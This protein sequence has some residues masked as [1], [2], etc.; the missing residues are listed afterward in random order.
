[1]VA[2]YKHKNYPFIVNWVI[3]ILGGSLLGLFA[4]DVNLYYKSVFQVWVF[5]H[6][7]VYGWEFI[8][9]TLGE[10]FGRKIPNEKGVNAKKLSTEIFDQEVLFY[11]SSLMFGWPVLQYK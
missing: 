3:L 1:M 2:F 8:F 10:N 7:F 6:I 4:S 9:K 11:V 5:T